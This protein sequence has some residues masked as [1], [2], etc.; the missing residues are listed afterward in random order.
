MDGSLPACKDWAILDANTQANTELS[1]TLGQ[2]R[3]FIQTNIGRKCASF[4]RVIASSE[5]P[6]VI[7][8]ILAH[9]DDNDIIRMLFHWQGLF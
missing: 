6:S 1:H 5:D 3:P 7:Q 4:V 9:L 2:Y 8:K